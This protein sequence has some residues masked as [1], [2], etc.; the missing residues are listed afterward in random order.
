MD[1]IL[2]ALLIAGAQGSAATD[3]DASAHKAE[4][5]SSLLSVAKAVAVE[6]TKGEL[7]TREGTHE[8]VRVTFLLSPWGT[9]YRL[10][11]V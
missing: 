10:R 9:M 2:F 11:F 3:C 1:H 6:P 8:C 7:P 5:A 4:I